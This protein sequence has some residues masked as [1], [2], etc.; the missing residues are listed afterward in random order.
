M[1]FSPQSITRFRFT[2]YEFDEA[3][4]SVRLHYAF[5]DSHHFSETLTFPGADL[6]LSDERRTALDKVLRELHLVAGISYYK[7]AVPP[8]IKLETGE[9][10]AA[11]AE[12]L[13]TLYLHGLGE[14]AHKNRLDLR[15]GMGFKPLSPLNSRHLL[16]SHAERGNEVLH[17]H[18]ER[19]NEVVVPIGGGKDSL[20]TLEI[21]RAANLPIKL[22]SVGK[23]SAIGAT[24]A[25][26]GLPHIVIQ[27]QLDPQLFALNQQ[28]AYNG[29]VPI[30]AILAYIFAA[31]SILYGFDTVVMSNERSANVGNFAQDGFE[32][33]HQYSKS[34]AFEHAVQARFDNILP[35]FR[36][37]SLLRALSELDIARL[38]ARCDTYDAVFSSCNANYKIHAQAS[39]Q[40]RWCLNC[41]KCRF[42]FL[43]LAPFMSQARLLSI[44]GANLL[45]DPAQQ[46]GF[47]A[48]IGHDAHKPFEC[49][50]EV[51]E[52][53]AAFY[54]L[55][56]QHTWQKSALIQ[57]FCANILPH[58]E[59]PQALLD[60]A[61]T[62]SCQH[63][64][65]QD[66]WGFLEA[67]DQT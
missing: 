20:V 27:R 38:F 61:L 10:D 40:G 2:R 41:P 12:F 57:H 17:S 34:L 44:F 47:D 66:F 23:P 6:P 3:T 45:D 55:S 25:L 39:H 26:S 30:S 65:P 22:I 33:N 21:L 63:R 14:F 67:Y 35:G 29:H 13:E 24:A 53:L 7:A 1:P 48:L 46:A 52:S 31:A 50:G 62:P 59:N 5:D 28:G 60:T 56:Q 11:T 58:L 9:I 49:V 18:A 15:G 8:Q 36:Y 32:V 19:G 64:I 42:V 4:Q 16:H 54:L 43:A 51:E 37:F